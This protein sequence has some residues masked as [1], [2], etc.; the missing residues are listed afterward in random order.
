M[1]NEDQLKQALKP[2]YECLVFDL[3]DTLYPLSSGLSAQITKNIQEYMLQK[4]GIEENKV[5][6]LCVALY[7][8]YGTTLAGLKAIGYNFEYD[9]FHS[10]VHG[11]LP[12][13][14]LKPDPVLRGL[15]LS[16]PIRKVIFTNSDKAHTVRALS[17]LGLEDC[18]EGIISFETL[19]PTH[20]NGFPVEADDK[21]GDPRPSSI[22][23]TEA[24]DINEYLSHPNASLEL[25]RTPV[26]CKPFEQ[27]YDEVFKTA[28]IDPQRTL[29][30]DDSLHN[31]QA[32][33]RVGLHTVLV[34]TPHRTQGVDYALE[35]IHN[36]REALPELW[37]AEEKSE[38][39]SYSGKVAIET[40]V[41]A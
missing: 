6:Q 38:S 7:K 2:K 35:S 41:Q 18:F 4:L 32:G 3:D 28:N 39:V 19:N 11:R 30:F 27:A 31:I 20:K 10:Y 29:F 14:M 24:F 25:P 33:K 1:E 26:V 23:S 34:G 9:D 5:P 21:D 40:Y 17:R 13:H 12:Y 36:I 8:D 22:S 37:E 16:L 15:L